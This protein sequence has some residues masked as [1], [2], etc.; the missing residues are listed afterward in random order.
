MSPHLPRRNFLKKI[1]TASLYCSLAS[2]A[3]KLH[4]SETSSSAE[5]DYK[6]LVLLFLSGGNDAYNLMAPLT[7]DLR[8]R[9]D[10][11]RGIVAL[12]G[13]DLHPIHS[14]TD[15][16]LVDGTSYNDFGLH[17]A[18]PDIAQ[19]FN[20]GDLS[21]V[22]NIGNLVEPVSYTAY[23]NK[24]ASLPPQL[25]SHSDQQ[26]QYQSEPSRIFNFGWG[27]RTAEHLSLY[28]TSQSLSPLISL[29]GLN[30]FQVSLEKNI[31]SYGISSNGSASLYGFKSANGGLRDNMILP[32]MAGETGPTG[33]FAQKYAQ[34][35]TSAQ[36]AELILNE[37]FNIANNNGVAYDDI[38]SQAAQSTGLTSTQTKF[39]TLAKLIA[40]RSA[41]PN[42]RPIFF[43]TMSGYDHHQNLLSSQQN[44]LR[45]LNAALKGF[46]DALVQQGDFDKVVTMVGS[47]FGRTF[48]PNGNT[49]D[50]G[51]DHGWGG[52]ALFMGGPV[53]GSK[54]MGIH[55]DFRFN[56]GLDT[57]RGRWIP[58]TS[59]VE[60]A[61]DL[62]SWMGVSEAE[63]PF[64]FPTVSNFDLNISPVIT[65]KGV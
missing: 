11:G 65:E 1:S 58:T 43:L 40:G 25:Y 33:L 26:R 35:F 38:F 3:N 8:Y 63:L 29:S 62:V 21:M 37:T 34:I 15:V 13:S 27:G 51:T 46:K 47:E 7:G 39:K 48:N 60:C 23:H 14:Q 36:N 64:I 6:A 16:P 57:G 56:E 50:A 54:I 49:S 59:T 24:S 18:C 32:A 31:N 2:A 9:Y 41:N 12:P 10:T 28:N 4:A 30:P 53:H 22:C 17:P 52:H 44:L 5:G 20:S 55:P 45:D 61:A 19:M 42:S